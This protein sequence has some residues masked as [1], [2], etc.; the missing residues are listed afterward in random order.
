MEGQAKSILPLLKFSLP[1]GLLDIDDVE[2]RVSVAFMHPGV[3]LILARLIMGFWS[4]EE[5]VR[6]FSGLQPTFVGSVCLH[7]LWKP[8]VGCTWPS[9]IPIN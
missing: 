8:H 1:V 5:L 3:P 7:V 2:G 4:L 6:H 9:E